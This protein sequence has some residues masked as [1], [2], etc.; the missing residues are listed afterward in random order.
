[1]SPLDWVYS[2]N[3]HNT[4]WLA[5]QEVTRILE[6]FQKAWKTGATLSW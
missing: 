2:F 6:N 5:P 3:H 4:L 1:M